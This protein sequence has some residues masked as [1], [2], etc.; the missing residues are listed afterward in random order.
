MFPKKNAKLTNLL[1]YTLKTSIFEKTERDEVT[2][3]GRSV[4]NPDTSRLQKA[5][6]S[7]RTSKVSEVGYVKSKAAG[8][9][10]RCQTGQGVVCMYM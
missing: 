5:T 10:S 7:C 1:K 2:L 9:S 3:S 8:H 4:I 6:L